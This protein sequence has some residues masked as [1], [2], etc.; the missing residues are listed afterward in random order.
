MKKMKIVGLAALVALTAS[1]STFSPAAAKPCI[2]CCRIIIQ[3][4]V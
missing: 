3:C 4:G 2:F 1:L